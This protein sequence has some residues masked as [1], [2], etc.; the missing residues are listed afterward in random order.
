MNSYFCTLIIAY[1]EAATGGVLYE[2]VFLESSKNS[3]ENTCARVS[4]LIK[5]QV[6][7]LGD[8]FYLQKDCSV[9]F[10]FSSIFREVFIVSTTRNDLKILFVLHKFISKVG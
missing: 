9:L 6:S 5:L 2:K 7:S 8:C 1:T 4:F 3:Q 10:F